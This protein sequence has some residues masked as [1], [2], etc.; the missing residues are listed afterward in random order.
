[1]GRTAD[2][3]RAI[4]DL[5]CEATSGEKFIVELQREAQDFFQDRV[6][7]YSTFPIQEQAE[8][9][10]WNFELAP[11]YCVGILDFCFQNEE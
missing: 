5:Y 1:M 4:F 3:R 2:D 9:G 10:H 8:K 11:V 6:V 7:Y